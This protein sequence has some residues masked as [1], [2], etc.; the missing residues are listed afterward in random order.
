MIE[1]LNFLKTNFIK[2]LGKFMYGPEFGN[3]IP[4]EENVLI[5]FSLNFWDKTFDTVVNG[6]YGANH[7]SP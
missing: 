6:Y 4:K 2:G 1:Q 3:D 7:P 5:V